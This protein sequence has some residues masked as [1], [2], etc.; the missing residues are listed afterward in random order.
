MN[1]VLLIDDD[2]SFRNALAENLR[3]DGLT[4]V[5]CAAAADVPPL[6][7]LDGVRVVITDYDMPETNGLAFA[8][9]FHAA[10]PQ[11]PVLL[12][13]AVPI[14][15]LHAHAAMR[16]FVRLLRKPL[17]YGELRNVLKQIPP[18]L[19]NQFEPY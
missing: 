9:V 8:D 16:G 15:R 5:E 13:T 19:P 7:T 10:H 14:H 2:D 3:D 4:V 6:E 12:V 17:D 11:V 1:M 18:S